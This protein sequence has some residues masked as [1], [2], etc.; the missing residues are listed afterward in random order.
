MRILWFLF[1]II[2]IG[3][4]FYFLM[5][6]IIPVYFPGIIPKSEKSYY[7]ANIGGKTFRL[8][9]ARTDEKRNEGLGY[10]NSMPEDEG[11]IFLLDGVE[12]GEIWMK[13]MR[14]PLDVI[15]LYDKK[16]VGIMVNIKTEPL[17]ED[18]DL[19]LYSPS[20]PANAFIE[21]NAGEVAKTSLRAGDS[22]LW[23]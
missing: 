22:V 8:E 1:F 9:I 11:M 23:E 6:N 17:T 18:K 7:D 19:K 20:S 12:R 16:V 15:W 5:N 2:I 4:G 10:R 13:G 14:F 21:L 3:A